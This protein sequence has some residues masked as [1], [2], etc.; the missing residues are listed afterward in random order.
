M[1]MVQHE[2]PGTV[3]KDGGTGVEVEYVPLGAS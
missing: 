3:F 2:S 1:P